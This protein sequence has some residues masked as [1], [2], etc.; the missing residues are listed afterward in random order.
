MAEIE[1]PKFIYGAVQSALIWPDPDYDEYMAKTESI[2]KGKYP[3][4][5][6]LR[7][8]VKDPVKCLK[9]VYTTVDSNRN[10]V[11]TREELKRAIRYG[12]NFPNVIKDKDFE[13]LFL[14]LDPCHTNWIK[15]EKFLDL[16]RID[17]RETFKE[18]LNKNG[19]DK[20]LTVFDI[21]ER[22]KECVKL[23]AQQIL[24]DF[25]NYDVDNSGCIK[26]SH[27]KYILQ[28]HTFPIHDSIFERLW[29]NFPKTAQNELKYY[30]FLHEY[31]NIALVPRPTCEKSWI[32]HKVEGIVYEDY[33][34][35]GFSKPRMTSLY[36]SDCDD[37]LKKTIEKRWREIL[38]R[39]RLL[40]PCRT[41]HIPANCLIEVLGQ[42]GI[43]VHNESMAD[44]L[45]IKY[46][47]TRQN[48]MNY[49]NFLRK[50]ISSFQDEDYDL[51][52]KLETGD[53]FDNKGRFAP[54]KILLAIRGQVLHYWRRLR[55]RFLEKDPD[56][57]GFIDGC[58]FRKILHDYSIYFSDEEF[59][60]ILRYF[61]P[62]LTGK[63]PYSSFLQTYANPILY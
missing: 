2:K 22:L 63:V 61:D 10:Q 45:E 37:L 32:P 60:K 39:C 7:H 3:V 44:V 33:A 46:G 21:N 27:V 38:R 14:L 18:D 9:M 4:L 53:I 43:P 41:G 24:K 40:D 17:P 58:D 62:H 30:D 19:S 1:N 47:F 49:W 11:V 23:C 13:D 42:C 51:I 31:G 29:R 52:T 26:K 59:F 5:E 28:K 36:A 6:K 35:N 8:E 16:F 57:T 55:E 34:G 48:I 54:Y 20:Y 56:G 12:L 25:L 50:C 15:C